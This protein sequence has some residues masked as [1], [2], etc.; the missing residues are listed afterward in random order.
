[1]TRSVFASMEANLKPFSFTS[2]ANLLISVIIILFETLSVLS[3]FG[4]SLADGGA[5]LATHDEKAFFDDGVII[6]VDL[7]DSATLEY[8]PFDTSSTHI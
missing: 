6:A 2:V 5:V 8:C 1:M 4:V 7:S 3:V